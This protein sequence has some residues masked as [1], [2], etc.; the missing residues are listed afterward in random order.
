[1]MPCLESLAETSQ[2]RSLLS[3]VPPISVTAWATF[4]T[5]VNPGEPRCFAVCYPSTQQEHSVPHCCPRGLS[6]RHVLSECG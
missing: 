6:R 3:T 2:S 4:I 5:G 1:M